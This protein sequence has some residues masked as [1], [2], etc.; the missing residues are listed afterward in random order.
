MSESAIVSL[1]EYARSPEIV[2]RFAEVVGE[3]N[4]NAYISSV[5][6]AVSMNDTLA[7]CDPKSII[8]TALR[9]ATMRLSCDPGVGH[10]YPVPFKGKAVLV[11]GYKGLINM[12]ERTGKY[13]YINAGPV[14]EGEEYVEDRITGAAKIEGSKVSN[15]V[16]GYVASFQLLT[17]FSKTIYMSVE[18]IHELA[19][20][21]SKSYNF[22]DSAWKTNTKE[23]ERK[24]VLRRL[25]TQ[26]GY[27]D[28][29]DAMMLSGEVGEDVIDG[30]V[31]EEIQNLPAPDE[32]SQPDYTH[33]ASYEDVFGQPEPQPKSN[34]KKAEPESIDVKAYITEKAQ[35]CVPAASKQSQQLAAVLE[36][37]F[38]NSS[39]SRY[40]FMS[41]LSGKS[42]KTSKDIDQRMITALYEWLDPKYDKNGGKFYT[43]N[44][45]AKEAITHAHAEYLKSIGQIELF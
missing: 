9:A 6:L 34:G 45:A 37:M 36:G 42:V 27:L 22:N 11:V 17:G 16:I 19:K 39:A 7:N 35:H 24:T 3:R 2:G 44:D 40:E 18:E 43:E 15:T 5:L 33:P 4:A 8:G 14:F 12:A 32:V 13:R 23:M 41:Y 26:W 10:A 31:Y 25:L 38:N 20:K 1:K 29:N 21:H 28:P 30:E